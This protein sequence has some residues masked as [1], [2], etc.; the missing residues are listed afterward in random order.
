ML[1]NFT[2]YSK[3]NEM[4]RPK[5]EGANSVYACTGIPRSLP[6]A[7]TATPTGYRIVNHD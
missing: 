1:Y 6:A 5:P 2:V 7:Y 3:L 4:K